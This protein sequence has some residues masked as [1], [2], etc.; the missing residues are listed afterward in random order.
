MARTNAPF[1]GL[2]MM[3]RDY[4]ERD[5]L[6]KFLTAQRGPL[7]FYVRGARRRGF[8]LASDILPFTYGNYVGLLADDGLSYLVSAQETHHWR[9]IEGDLNR[10]A[11][12]TYLLDLVD[13]AF[14]E[15][16]GIGGWYPQ[17][18]AALN[19]IDQGKDPQVIANVMAVQ[20]LARFGVAPV[21]DGCV[22]CGRADRPLDYSESFGGLLCQNHWGQDPYRLHLAPKV[23]RYLQLFA[24]LNLQQVGAVAVDDRTK[25]GLDQA[26][27][28]IYD[29]QVGL[30]LRSKRFLDQM[31]SWT[32][33]LQRRRGSAAGP[34]DQS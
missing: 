5:L 8:K 6:V 28:K 7:M 4:R 19:L 10:N 14:A 9:G 25:Q 16:Q 31:A 29:N 2:V 26:L 32:T 34:S 3:R 18:V 30:H 20:L 24:H 13:A 21:W 22:I 27:T 23:V 11:Y 33:R 12:A 15:G 1:A 17:I